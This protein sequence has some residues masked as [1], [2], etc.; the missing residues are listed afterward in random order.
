MYSLESS[1][2]SCFFYKNLARRACCVNGRQCSAAF[3][4]NAP[5]WAQTS[6]HG[7]AKLPCVQTLHRLSTRLWKKP[8]K[9]LSSLA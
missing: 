5:E 3:R 1:V 4:Y 2:D 9:T 7:K 8:G 6:G